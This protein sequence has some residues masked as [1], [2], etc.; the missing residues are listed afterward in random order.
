[1]LLELLYS[2]RSRAQ[3]QSLASELERM[4]LLDADPAVHA[5]ALETQSRLADRSR[6]RGPTPSDLI[7]A[8]VA[9]THGV[10]LLHYDRHFD[11]IARVTGQPAVWVVRRGT[12]D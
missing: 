1:V 3:Y 5:L 4:P 11:A 9:E 7:I 2:A 10:T 6:H 8:A 12:L